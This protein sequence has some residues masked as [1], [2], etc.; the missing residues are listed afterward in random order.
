MVRGQRAR[1]RKFCL[2]GEKSRRKFSTGS[3][4]A[5]AA[6]ARSE[7]DLPHERQPCP[8]PRSPRRFPVPPSST[9][10]S[11]SR[12]R[13]CAMRAHCNRTMTSAARAPLSLRGRSLFHSA[14]FATS[15]VG[16]DLSSR[17][18]QFLGSR[19]AISQLATY[20]YVP[21]RLPVAVRRHFVT[22]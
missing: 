22:D 10:R 15:L 5:T 8:A 17:V 21:F 19:C 7:P 4:G 2:R 20:I 11:L 18:L 3:S 12:P 16:T 9:I 1:W 14:S 13:P 6:G